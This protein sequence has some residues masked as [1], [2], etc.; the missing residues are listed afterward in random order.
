M[1]YIGKMQSVSFDTYR[2]PSPLRFI[3]QQTLHY[4]SL[5]LLILI[6]L[7]IALIA[8][9]HL[10]THLVLVPGLSVG[11]ARSKL[12]LLYLQLRQSIEG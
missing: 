12:P 6:G 11:R 2:A 7:A 9:P 4:I 5:G 3:M 1:S 10:V 8:S